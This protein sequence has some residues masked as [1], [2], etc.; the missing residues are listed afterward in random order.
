MNCASWA[1]HIQ[2]SE[3]EQ[4]RPGKTIQ[5]R[6][7]YNSRSVCDINILTMTMCYIDY[8]GKVKEEVG[9]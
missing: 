9:H 1:W 3:K 7:G 4:S 8:L 5:K 2:L 6:H